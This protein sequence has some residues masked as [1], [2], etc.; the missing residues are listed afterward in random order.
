MLLSSD[1]NE[2][3]QINKVFFKNMIQV[4]I[5]LEQEMSENQVFMHEGR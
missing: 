4:C 1:V 5:C 2:N 3:E